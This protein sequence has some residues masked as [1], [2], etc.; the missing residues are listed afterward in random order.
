MFYWQKGIWKS[1]GNV[2]SNINSGN[3]ALR[4][5]DKRLLDDKYR[6]SWS[7]QHNRYTMAQI[8]IILKLLAR[9]ASRFKLMAIR[10][11]DLSKRPQNT[12]EE[13]TYAIFCN[14]AKVKAGIGTQDAM[15]KNLFVDLHRMG[16]IERY[17][18]NR[19][20]VDPFSRRSI[21]YV[22]LTKQGWRLIKG[23]TLLDRYFIFSKAID[24]LL[25]GYIGVLLNL[26]RDEEYELQ[27]ISIYEFMFFVSAVGTDTSFNINIDTCAEY[28]NEYRRLSTIQKRVVVE[29]LKKK[30]QPRNYSGTKLVERDFHN[31]YNKAQQIFSLL[32]QTIYFDVRKKVLVLR[33]G[34]ENVFEGN[35]NIR[36]LDRSLNEKYLYYKNHNVEKALGFELHHVIP[37]A[38]S[39]NFFQF[40]LLDTW[41]NMIYIDAYSHAKITQNR[42]KNIIMSSNI[43]DI[44]LNDYDN[45]E[46][47]LKYTKNILYDIRQKNNMLK[48]NKELLKTIK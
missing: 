40:K 32:G 34:K 7:S 1:M 26:L 23:K 29:Q 10:H 8:V 9:Y 11:T 24:R 30:L 37:L 2:V 22:S 36:R 18:K 41:L 4:F 39:E 15:R 44:S 27:D 38:W 45:G 5:I 43:N 20:C 46:V 13:K 6:G 19:K 35:D 3:N 14:E 31:W 48:Y 47:Y 33:T 12:P 21:Y 17:D 28:I 42:N 25:N 16:L